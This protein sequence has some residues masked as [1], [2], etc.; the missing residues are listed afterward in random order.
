MRRGVVFT[1]TGSYKPPTQE[2]FCWPE[3]SSHSCP[4]KRRL[5]ASTLPCK[6]SKVTQRCCIMCLRLSHLFRL[7]PL[8]LLLAAALL[9]VAVVASPVPRANI[10]KV[11]RRRPILLRIGEYDWKHSGWKRKNDLTSRLSK[12]LCI[13]D[14]RCFGYTPAKG[15]GE[16]KPKT[17]QRSREITVDNNYYRTMKAHVDPQSF[18][19]GQQSLGESLSSVARLQAAIRERIRIKD[20]ESCIRAILD[21]MVEK[22]IAIDYDDQKS[23]E[24]NMA[25]IHTRTLSILR[26]GFH[27]WST[28]TWA[29]KEVGIKPNFLCLPYAKMCLGFEEKESRVV[30]ISPQY[31]MG[32]KTID[33]HRHPSLVYTFEQQ[34]R[35]FWSDPDQK[36]RTLVQFLQDT[37]DLKKVAGGDI[38]DP[39]SYIRAVLRYLS[40][41]SVGIIRGYDSTKP[42]LDLIEPKGKNGGDGQD[43]RDG[44]DHTGVDNAGIAQETGRLAHG[45][46]QVV[47]GGQEVGNGRDSRDRTA[48]NAGTEGNNADTVHSAS[49]I[50]SIHNLI[51]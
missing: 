23:L 36:H 12:V 37:G 19:L 11:Q 41:D 14:I 29:D 20:D 44:G 32:K 40:L 50:A 39:E 2:L 13:G 1:N 5:C 28:N 47:R 7:Y 18:E 33:S 38:T 46:G 6:S 22:G 34:N 30:V 3:K 26:F 21:L 27:D 16:V 10:K 42:L 35:G 15:I 9:D 49:K 17:T 31:N 48:N 25:S 45:D 24:D 4:R 8:Y 51:N 43:V